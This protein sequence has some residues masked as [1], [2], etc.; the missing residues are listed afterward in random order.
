M[1]INGGFLKWSAPDIMMQSQVVS[2]PLIQL[3]NSHVHRVGLKIC[4][5]QNNL[6]TLLNFD[7]DCHFW[8]Y[9][10]E[11]LDAKRRLP[12]LHISQLK[13]TFEQWINPPAC[14]PGSFDCGQW[15]LNKVKYW[16]NSN[17]VIFSWYLWNVIMLVNQISVP[18]FCDVLAL[19][20]YS[21]PQSLGNF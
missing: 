11:W 1:W 9:I 14:F 13:D 21:L 8:R 18:S 12:Q 20:F 3:D 5:L 6:K 15:E 2:L 7:N 10:W 4:M 17:Y 19:S 16:S